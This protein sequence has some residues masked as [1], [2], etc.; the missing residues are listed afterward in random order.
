MNLTLYKTLDGD[1]VINKTLTDP[2]TMTINLKADSDLVNLTILL[3][4]VPG[5]DY[6]DYNYCEIVELNR[7]YF[8][9]KLI[10]LSNDIFQLDCQCDVL[11]TYKSTILSSHCQYRRKVV[12]GDYGPIELDET[13]REIVTDFESDVTLV[14]TNNSIL[15]VMNWGQ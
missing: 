14:P 12:A 1:N 8:I 2:S 4:A 15:S 10:S 9:R 3:A 11:E 7:F 6:Q 5:I 13:G